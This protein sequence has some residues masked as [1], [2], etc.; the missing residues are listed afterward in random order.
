MTNDTA[1]LVEY[2]VR[3]GDDALI[4][5]H[6]LSEWSGQ[7]PTL[8]ED[9]ALS[10]LGL[11]LIG[12]ARLL[13]SLA[14]AREGQGRDEDRFAYFRDAAAFKNCLLV[15]QPNGD[16]AATIVRHLLFAAMMHPYYQ[17]L[18]SSRDPALAEIAVKAAKEMA[19]HVRHAAE[20]AIR[21]GDGTAESHRRMA[22]ALDDLWGYS[23]ELFEMDAIETS[24]AG[25]AIVPDRAAIRPRFEATIARV[26]A[27]AALAVPKPRYMQTGGRHGRHT[28]HLGHLLAEMQVLARAHPEAVW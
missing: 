19:Y 4:L 26:L 24:L 20:W 28:E 21:L 13:Y 10:N 15:E 25:K 12:Q 23:G 3:L 6:R 18:S 22:G 2:C 7:A 14:G 16:F 17:A 8:E 9:I 11:D 1:A 5:G 27:E